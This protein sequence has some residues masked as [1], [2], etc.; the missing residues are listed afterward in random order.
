MKIRRHLALMATAVLVP[1]L[2]FSALS[3]NS[4]LNAERESLL[5]GMHAAASAASLAV[6]REW[7]YADGV[8]RALAESRRLAEGDLAGFYQQAAGAN[9]GSAL[10]TALIGADARQVFNT[11]LPFGSRIKP[12]D[13]K[14][15]ARIEGVLAGNGAQISNLIIGRATGRHVVTLERPV[16]LQDG[17]R[18]VLS[19]WY[20]ASHFGAGISSGN[21]PPSWVVGL[22]DAD[23]V[24]VARNRGPQDFVG[25]R[26][27]PD[28]LAAIRS[29]RVAFIRNRSRDGVDLYTVLAHSKLSGWTVAVGVPVSVVE[30]SARNA[31]LLTGAGLLAAIGFAVLA[32]WLFGRRLLNAFDN[33]ERAAIALGRGESPVLEHSPI[34]EVGKLE[35]ALA[36]AGLALQGSAAEREFL[37]ADAREARL[38]AESQN[39][40]KDDFLAMLGHELRNPLSAITAGVSLLEHAAVP[41][42]AKARAREAIRRQCG[43]LTNIV[44]ELLDASRVMTGKVSLSKRPLD[45]GAATRACLDAAA[46]R[47]VGA[48]YQVRADIDSVI[49]DGDPTRIEQIIT[50]LFDNAVKYTPA[51]GS[52]DVSV[53]AE[54]GD[55]VLQVRDSGI[56]IGPALLPKIFDV[57]MQ[58]AA[59]LDRAKGG[60]GIGLA[61]VRAMVQQHGGSVA[62]DSG[63][64]GKGSTFTVRFPRAQGPW[65]VQATHEE[66]GAAPAPTSV[67]VIDDND[68]ARE[69][70]AQVLTMNGYRVQQAATGKLGVTMAGQSAP[71]VAVVDIGLPDISGYE[72]ARQLRANAASARTRLVALTGYGQDSDRQKALDSGFDAHMTKPADIDELM[73]V[74]AAKGK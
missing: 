52:I 23:G 63:G 56:G 18:M 25:K 70:L 5:Q 64:E 72:V 74:I 4:L 46:M 36:N 48:G 49:I 2:L 21:L 61:V 71:Q 45:L 59:S 12:A 35:V 33:A 42:E 41:D 16:L 1:V 15:R 58:G 39:R 3:L 27:H 29:G 57:F 34:E 65:Q 6:E 10:H 31:V 68:D 51:G 24:T 19:Q 30:A 50:N 9:S 14:T 66:K 32:A 22:F 62:A 55:A 67:L 13:P 26:P 40:A 69:M 43:L 54:R 44:D 47:G 73:R 38:V 17:R 60:L 37:L 8:A 28:L 20:Y 11:V 7:S 53:H